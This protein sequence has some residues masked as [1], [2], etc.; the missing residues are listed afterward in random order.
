VLADAVQDGGFPPLLLDPIDFA[1][2]YVQQREAQATAETAP[3]G[4]A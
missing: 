4:N 1:S 3:V 2:L